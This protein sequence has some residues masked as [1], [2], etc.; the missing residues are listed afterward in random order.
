MLQETCAYI[1]EVYLLTLE[2]RR[3]PCKLRWGDGDGDG[4]DMQLNSRRD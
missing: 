2:P 3:G 4:D 1:Y